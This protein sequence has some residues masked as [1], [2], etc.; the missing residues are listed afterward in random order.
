[1]PIRR[2]ATTFVLLLS[3]V[4]P[5]RAAHEIGPFTGPE[6][7]A[8]AARLDERANDYVNNVV[9]GQYSY[10]Y[11]QFHWK[12]AGSN[13][14]RILRAYPSSPTAKKIQA[15]GLTVGTFQP[16]YFKERVL[17]RLEEKKVAAF[18]AINCAIFLL[19][20]EG[21]KDEQARHDLLAQIISTLCRQQRWSEALGFPVLD[22]ERAWL[23]ELVTRMAVI[24]RNQ[25][26]AD[27]LLSNTAKENLPAMLAIIGENLAF[28]GEPL[29]ALET[30]IAKYPGQAGVRPAVFAG[31]LRR[32]T[33]IDHLRQLKLPLDG[34]YAG[35]DAIQKPA[36]TID[37][38]AFLNTIPAGP[39]QQEARYGYACYLATLGRLDEAREFAAESNQ[40]GL[41]LSYARHLIA[42][43]EYPR[44]LALPE[45]FHLSPAASAQFRTQLVEVLAQAGRDGELAAVQ[46]QIPAELTPQAVY[47]EWRGRILCTQNQLVVREHVFG[48]I[49]LA[50]PNRLGQLICEWS[51]TPNRT[52]RGAS[53]W[54]AVVYKFAPGYANLPPPKDRNKVEA[55]SR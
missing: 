34:L 41:V 28:R 1:M 37:L 17:P 53:P 22:T 55:A 36:Q 51:L 35:V 24:Y 29:D 12:R 40:T 10:A 5:A 45:F 11:I 54:D 42:I 13:I 7:D 9:E 39:A 16:V 20:L 18:D 38:L 27:E 44:A 3:L 19:N 50:D 31:L 32:Q 33:P 47:H 43:E 21:N 48:N 52:L 26:I 2:L 4:L 49:P 8:E 30:F 23:W 6:A 15:D 25:K 14:E 46:T